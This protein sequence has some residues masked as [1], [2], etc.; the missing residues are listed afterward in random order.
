VGRE[1]LKASGFRASGFLNYLK[2]RRWNRATKDRKSGVGDG[3][4][5][6]KVTTKHTNY[7][8]GGF[9]IGESEVV[10][11]NSRNT[12][13]NQSEKVRAAEFFLKERARCEGRT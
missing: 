2:K 13:K 1:A 8:K 9:Q 12:R 3:N 4:E 10:P 11:R 7:T 6:G 5:V